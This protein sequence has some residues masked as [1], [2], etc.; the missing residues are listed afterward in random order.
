[1]AE[2]LGAG[3]VVVHPPFRWQREYARTFD[4]GLARNQTRTCGTHGA[5]VD[6]LVN[7]GAA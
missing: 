5:R 6:G 2:E 3:T 4:E 1:M 7:P